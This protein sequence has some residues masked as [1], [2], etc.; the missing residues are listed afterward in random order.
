MS[1]TLLTEHHLRFLSLKEAT[2]ARLSLYVSKSHIFTV[3]NV[4][5]TNQ[6]VRFCNVGASRQRA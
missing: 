2:Q 1:V 3:H 5:F 6:V 4:Y